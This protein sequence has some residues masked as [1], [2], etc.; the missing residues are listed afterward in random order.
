MKAEEERK[1][2]EQ[3]SK[4]PQISEKAKKLVN[5]PF[6]ERLDAIGGEKSEL[7]KKLHEKYDP[8]FT[9]EINQMVQFMIFRANSLLK[10]TDQSHLLT[11]SLRT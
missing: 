2:T 11:E 8:K 1:I 5:K 7:I 3:L 6:L 10:F 9:P 4:N